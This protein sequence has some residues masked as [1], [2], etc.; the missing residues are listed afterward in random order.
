[1]TGAAPVAESQKRPDVAAAERLLSI[2]ADLALRGQNA[3][4]C[5]LAGTR[6]V[7][8]EHYPDGDA[9]DQTSGYQWFYHSHAPQD[10]PS[11]VE[12]GHIHLFARW[13]HHR[14]RPTADDQAFL[15]LT[16]NPRRRPK[17]RHLLSIGFNA[18]GIP[19]S[20]FTVNSWVTGDLMLSAP[21]TLDLLDRLS[22]QT[23]YPVI[24][25]LIASTCQLYRRDIIRLLQDRDATLAAYSGDISVLEATQ[26][27]VLSSFAVSID[28][29]LAGLSA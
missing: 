28:E 27:E 17:T 1:M 10:R 25:G 12:H 16:G 3:L 4:D 9:I 18:T 5:L 14:C 24:D 8:W 23:A 6:P 15:Q 26:C 2:Y 13:S 19:V 20:L 29:A 11:S 21:R 22:L 7:Q